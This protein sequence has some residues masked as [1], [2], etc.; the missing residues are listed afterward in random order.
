[1]AQRVKCLSL[2][3]DKPEFGSAEPTLKLDTVV[4]ASVRLMYP[5]QEM[6]PETGESLEALRLVSLAGIHNNE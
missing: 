4:C 5:Y 1:M 3:S 6:G 2:K